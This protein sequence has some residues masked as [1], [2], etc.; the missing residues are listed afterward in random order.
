M[1][2]RVTLDQDRCAGHGICVDAAPRVFDID[3]E[4]GMGIVLLTDVD[5]EDLR[6]AQLA[7]AQCPER[8]IAFS[9][10]PA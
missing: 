4:T 2:T 6:A 3:E 7:A 8:A 10:P 1:G 5:G 9:A